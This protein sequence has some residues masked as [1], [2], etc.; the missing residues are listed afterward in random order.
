M[1]STGQL[2]HSCVPTGTHGERRGWSGK[3]FMAQTHPGSLKLWQALL[4]PLPL[5]LHRPAHLS[6]PSH[7]PSNRN[8][9][10]GRRASQ[11]HASPKAQRHA[12][13][14]AQV[15]QL[16]LLVR[17]EES[18]DTTDTL[19]PFLSVFLLYD[20]FYKHQK[21]IYSLI[22]LLAVIYSLL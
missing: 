22:D 5:S 6:P 12:S 20:N 18:V 21:L 15:F 17:D 11:S 4:P 3:R 19:W 8:A 16:Q 2:S 10:R 13:H 9:E 1:G 14:L 7:P